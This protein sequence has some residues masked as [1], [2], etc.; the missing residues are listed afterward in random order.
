LIAATIGVSYVWHRIKNWSMFYARVL[1]MS[2][3]IVV[4]MYFFIQ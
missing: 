4:M 2:I 3:L 1:M